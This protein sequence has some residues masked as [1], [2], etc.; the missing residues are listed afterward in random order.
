M[1][2]ILAQTVPP[3]PTDVEPALFKSIITVLGWVAAVGM[4]IIAFLRKPKTEIADQPLK[5]KGEVEYVTRRDFDDLKADLNRRF[6]ELQEER[7]RSIEQLHKHISSVGD[8]MGKQIENLD[9]T[10]EKR[11]AAGNDRMNQHGEDIAALK[12]L[13]RGGRK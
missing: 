4:G 11:L 10:Y 12:A 5:V 6:D 3:V 1:I 8:R 7:G 2:A 9:A 13:N